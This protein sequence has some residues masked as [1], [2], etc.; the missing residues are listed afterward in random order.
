MT[1]YYHYYVYSEAEIFLRLQYFS[2]ESEISCCFFLNR[3]FFFCG[4]D[5][6]VFTDEFHRGEIFDL[7]PEFCRGE[8]FDVG[9]IDPE[10]ADFFFG[11]FEETLTLSE[12]TSFFRIPDVNEAFGEVF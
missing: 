1:A 2:S 3:D 8:E 7:A 9:V 5:F 12:P 4:V 10:A 11:D 6:R